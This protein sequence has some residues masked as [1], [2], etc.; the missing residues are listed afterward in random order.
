MKN[1]F[2]VATSIAY[3]NSQPHI[4]YALELVQA[5]VLARYN[6]LLGKEVFFLTGTDEHGVK[7]AEKAKEEGVTPQELVDKNSALFRDLGKLLDLSND[8]FIRTTDDYH[9]EF[10]RKLW[11]T[12]FENGDIYKANYEGLYCVG[13]EKYVLEKELIDGNC[14]IHK[15]PPQK[16]NEENYFFKLSKYSAEIKAKIESDELRILPKSRKNEILSVLEE[17]L[18]DI[19]FSR[20]K[21]VLNWGIEVP[22]DADH[23]MYVWCDA[24]SNYASGVD[25][26]KFWPTE[27][28][29]IGKDILRF[30][31][32]IWVGMLLSVKMALPRSIYVHGFI[33]SEGE[34]MS[35]SMG[36]VVDPVGIVAKYGVEATRYYLLKEIPTSGDGDFSKERFEIVYKDELANVFGNL[37]SRVLAM[38]QKYFE[39]QV[40]AKGDDDTFAAA[41]EE[42]W[43]IYHQ[44]IG[45]FDLKKA[46]EAVVEFMNK[47]NKY[48]EDTKPWVLVKEN[49]ER[50]AQVIYNLLEAIRQAALMFLP[51]LPTSA[52]KI[53]GYLQMG[54]V[55]KFENLQTWGVLASGTVLEKGEILFPRLAE[56]V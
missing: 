6:R 5:D 44:Y 48:V 49:P 1:T 35:K 56:E 26:E 14:P 17:G 27:V 46:L 18:T 4:G 3:V 15:T 53:L 52:Q 20:P 34:K 54:P 23:V 12:M 22:N 40:P 2:Y 7:I 10:A 38:N 55:T 24:L 39:G 28:N 50:L 43:K 16:V 29:L 13:C 47:A 36:N 11:T 25:L 33:T 21:K 19:S 9:K 37:V 51:F 31:A 30:H 32:A 42:T 8:N 41:A 45:D